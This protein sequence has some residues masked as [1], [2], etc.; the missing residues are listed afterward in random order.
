VSRPV[1]RGV[2]LP[3]G[4]A[5]SEGARHEL[6]TAIETPAAE[7]PAGPRL[8][9]SKPGASKDWQPKEPVWDANGY[10]ISPP[11]R[12]VFRRQDP[13]RAGSHWSHEVVRLS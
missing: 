2:F 9:W 4:A 12:F 1:E 5:R 10:R 7:L 11:H 3:L 8:T 13:F 6:L